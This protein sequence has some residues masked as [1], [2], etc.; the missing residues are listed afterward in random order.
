MLID[1]RNDIETFVLWSG[2]SDFA[3]PVNQLLK[4]KKN[5]VIFATARRVSTELAE[6]RARIFDI[7]K[8]KEFICWSK[9]AKRTPE[10]ALK[11]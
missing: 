4:D 8:I 9:E 5:V 3:D 2:D 1:Y 6:T 7:K 11:L 10:G